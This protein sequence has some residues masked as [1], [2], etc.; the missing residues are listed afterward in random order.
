[1]KFAILSEVD[2]IVTDAEL[3]ASA[4]AMELAM[5]VAGAF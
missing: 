5:V 3:T 1:M 4:Q 2:M